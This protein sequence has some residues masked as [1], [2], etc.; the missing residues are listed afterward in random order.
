LN[1]L[2]DA[3]SRRWHIGEAKEDLDASISSLQ[4]AVQCCD[5]LSPSRLNCLK[6]LVDVLNLRY[7]KY[8][9]MSDLEEGIEDQPGAAHLAWKLQPE[10]EISLYNLALAKKLEYDRAGSPNALEDCVQFA[11][12]S[13]EKIYSPRN[14]RLLSIVLT[15]LF[16]A[17]GSF[18]D[19]NDAIE[20]L[21][22]AISIMDK[23][24]EQSPPG[25]YSN[26]GYA[27]VVRYQMFGAG[28]DVKEAM[29]LLLKALE[30]AKVYEPD[31][32]SSRHLNPCQMYF[33]RYRD[34]GN[35]MDDL[36]KAIQ[37][38]KLAVDHA[39]EDDPRLPLRRNTL[40]IALK[41][42]YED[43]GQLVSDINEAI[44]QLEAVRDFVAKTNASRPGYLYNLATAL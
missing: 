25:Y 30:L 1:N 33:A 5:P 38:G 39:R 23:R 13:V 26:L 42:R 36:D 12:K 8:R 20:Y 10:L 16:N 4:S 6:D 11:R 2:G 14:L 29:Y 22:K 3:L 18:E 35:E 17:K 15:A 9:L 27:L 7:E 19:I 21:Q 40:G 37:H 41:C 43:F 34:M 24:M 31:P 32:L 44:K 28:K